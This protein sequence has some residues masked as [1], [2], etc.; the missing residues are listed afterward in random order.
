[1]PDGVGQRLMHHQQRGSVQRHRDERIGVGRQGDR[2]PPLSLDP[3]AQVA[4][5][6]WRPAHLGTT[7]LLDDFAQFLLIMSEAALQRPQLTR[8]F[9]RREVRLLGCCGNIEAASGQRLQDPIVKIPADPE[10]LL[11][12]GRIPRA[13]RQMPMLHRRTDIGRDD[14]GEQDIVGR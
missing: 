2:D 4:Q 9:A 6:C 11:G 5:G 10:P 7:E 8:D 3:R 12:D 14:P 13:L 1:M